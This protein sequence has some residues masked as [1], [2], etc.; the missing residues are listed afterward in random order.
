MRKLSKR[1]LF[2]ISSAL[3]F[4]SGAAV[5][6]AAAPTANTVVASATVEGIA[7]DTATSI[8][9]RRVLDLEGGVNFRDLGGYKTADGRHVRWRT[10]FRSGDPS[11][12]TPNDL[13]TLDKLGVRTVCDFRTS[14]ER[15]EAPSRWIEMSSVNYWTRD[16]AMNPG[17]I[18][19]MFSDPELTPAKVRDSMAGF[20]KI[21]P[22]EHKESY[23]A[24]FGFLARNEVPLA[25]N[26]TAG[27]DRAGLGAALLLTAL[28]VPRETVLYDYSLTERVTKQDFLK[29]IEEEESSHSAYAF[30]AK[31][32]PELVKPL[33]ASDPYYL[34]T[35]FAAIEARYGSVDLFIEQELG[36]TPAI[37]EKMRKNLLVS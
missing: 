3:L 14:E 37:R 10:L 7:R 20:Y 33:M 27:K 16:Y 18:A 4:V 2:L 21:L 34:E 31:L 25:F 12:L 13:A 17:Q 1:N 29:E 30:L 28:G 23:K 22:F 5:G 26:C 32:P 6:G 19:K 36:V 35:A 24:M 9:P 8:D 11:K 15:K